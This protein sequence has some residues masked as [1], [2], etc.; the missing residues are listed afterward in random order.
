MTQQFID[1]CINNNINYVLEHYNY[2]DYIT[3]LD[4]FIHARASNNIHLITHMIKTKRLTWKDAINNT[5][6]CGVEIHNLIIDTYTESIQK[7]FEF[8][9]QEEWSHIITKCMTYLNI[10]W[11]KG[12]EIMESENEEGH[13]HNQEVLKFVKMAKDMRDKYLQNRMN[14]QSINK[15]EPY[16]VNLRDLLCQ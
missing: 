7:I 8:G 6:E 16:I 14:G 12:I 9:C 10:D 4:G 5:M 15:N 13:S 1:A 3:F 11:D 2:V